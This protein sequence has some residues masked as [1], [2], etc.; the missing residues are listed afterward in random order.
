MMF[1]SA[2]AFAQEK[3]AYRMSESESVVPKIVLEA[4]KSQCSHVKV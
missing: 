4:F 1:Q 3:I 2:H